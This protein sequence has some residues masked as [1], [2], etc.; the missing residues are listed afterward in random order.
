MKLLLDIDIKP[1]QPMIQLQDKIMLVGSCFTEHIRNFMHESGFDS[2]QNAHGIIFNPISVEKSLMDVIHCKKYLKDDLFYLNETWN[3]WMHHSRFSNTDADTCLTE[4]N[5]TIET[6]HLFLKSCKHLIITLGS[7]FAY[8]HLGKNIYVNNNHRAPQQDFK[9]ELLSVKLMYEKYIA[10]IDALKKFNPNLNIIFTISPVRHIRDGVQENNRS[11]A[12]LIELVHL[13]CDTDKAE[14]LYY[15]PSYELVIDVLRDYRF[16]DLD[17]VHPNY[18]ATQYVW[19]CFKEKC[20]DDICFSTM[21]DVE[22]I[23]RAMRHRTS[24]NE[25]VAHQKFRHDHL[26]LALKLKK[27]FP[28]LMLDDAIEFFRQ[29]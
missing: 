25:S 24:N 18:Q 19:Q 21:Q 5:S 1:L 3:S 23:H 20:I 12:R 11:K 4:I 29:G 8:K 26:L 13:L 27:E 7:A 2:M 14:S 6:H 16:Y 15:F 9:K 28:Y 22:K 17:M 10:L